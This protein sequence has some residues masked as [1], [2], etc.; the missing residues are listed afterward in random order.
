MKQTVLVHAGLFF[1]SAE[2]IRDRERHYTR[3]WIFSHKRKMCDHLMSDCQ[4]LYILMDETKKCASHM[5]P[6]LWLFVRE[7]PHSLEV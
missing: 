7:K 2:K 1:A 5:G 6:E 4:I 3:M